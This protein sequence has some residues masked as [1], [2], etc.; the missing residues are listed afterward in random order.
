M[1]PLP[2]SAQDEGQAFPF[3]AGKLH[4]A[5]EYQLF[6]RKQVGVLRISDGTTRRRKV[7]GVEIPHL[8][9][10]EIRSALLTRG[11]RADKGRIMD[12][13]ALDLQT[14]GYTW[15]SDR[16]CARLH[17]TFLAKG[18]APTVPSAFWRST[19]RVAKILPNRCRLYGFNAFW[20]I[21]SWLN[22]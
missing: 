9:S 7:E 8:P 14:F 13:F 19:N 5:S 22:Y 11:A 16:G 20:R 12:F 15:G 21:V 4:E 18:T 17:Q 3:S 1:R 2:Q 6:G 10:A